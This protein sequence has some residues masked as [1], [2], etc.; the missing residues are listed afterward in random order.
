MNDPVALQVAAHAAQGFERLQCVECAAS[1]RNALIAG[2]HH[3]TI[4]ELRGSEAGDFIVCRSYDEARTAIC[5][6]GRHIGVRVGDLAFDNLHPQG[7]P[8]EEWLLD[9]DAPGGVIVCRTEDF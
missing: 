1:I 6:N 4:I 9:F 5:Q 8:Y 2:Q 7:L 3:G